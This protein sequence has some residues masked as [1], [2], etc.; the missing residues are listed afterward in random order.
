MIEDTYVDRHI[1]I[2]CNYVL[3]VIYVSIYIIIYIHICSIVVFVHVDSHYDPFPAGFHCQTDGRWMHWDHKV[4][5]GGSRAGCFPAYFFSLVVLVCFRNSLL[6]LD[7]PLF[8]SVARGKLV[9][10]KAAASMVG[11]PVVSSHCLCREIAAFHDNFNGKF[12][13]QSAI[14]RI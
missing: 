8:W 11:S 3:H 12:M 14:C 9:D 4:G 5:Y 7:R 2:I 1:I 6:R 13:L 10:I